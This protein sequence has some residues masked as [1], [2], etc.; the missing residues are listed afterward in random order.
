MDKPLCK[1]KLK[2]PLTFEISCSHWHYRWIPRQSSSEDT[3]HFT[4]G[5]LSEPI[6][7]SLDF[8]NPTHKILGLL[9]VLFLYSTE[10]LQVRPQS[11]RQK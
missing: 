8:P 1:N 4:P 7:Y 3:I 6:I 10:V 5:L 11:F 2:Q 9:S